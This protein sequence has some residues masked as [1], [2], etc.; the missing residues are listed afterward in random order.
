MESILT[1]QEIIE[2]YEL[3]GIKDVTP[4]MISAGHVLIERGLRAVVQPRNNLNSK[5]GIL[6]EGLP[7]SSL[8]TVGNNYNHIG[9]EFTRDWAV[10]A[11]LMDAQQVSLNMRQHNSSK[12]WNVAL[13][14]KHGT[15]LVAELNTRIG[16]GIAALTEFLSKK[17]GNVTPNQPFFK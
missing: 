16:I 7:V 3:L 17:A 12:L 8:A 9:M 11:L 10:L 5:Q 4:E 15:L 6:I 14:D 1:E 13:F 2:T